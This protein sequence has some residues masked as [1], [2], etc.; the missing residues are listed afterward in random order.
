MEKINTILIQCKNVKYAGVA[1]TTDGH[2][3]KTSL[4]W[5]GSLRLLK[6]GIIAEAD[7]EEQV[8]KGEDDKERRAE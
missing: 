8:R 6:E 7:R 2:I 3:L 5:K 1:G 4:F